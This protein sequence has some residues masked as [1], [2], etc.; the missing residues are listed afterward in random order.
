MSVR[1][2][3]LLIYYTLQDS[4]DTFDKLLHVNHTGGWL[5]LRD[6]RSHHTPTHTP[7]PS[8]HT[9]PPHFP[10]PPP[11]ERRQNKRRFTKLGFAV[12]RLLVYLVEFSVWSSD[13]K[14]GR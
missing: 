12:C 1:V 13:F 8:P 7:T 4:F 11:T 5:Q 2:V 14:G 9:Y 6:V 10:P 3:D